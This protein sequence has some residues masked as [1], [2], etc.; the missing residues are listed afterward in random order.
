M[1]FTK[2]RLFLLCIITLCQQPISFGA[3]YLREVFLSGSLILWFLNGTYPNLWRQNQWRLLLCLNWVTVSMS[4]KKACSFINSVMIYSRNFFYVLTPMN[5]IHNQNTRW[6]AKNHMY[7]PLY[8][9]S[10]GQ[11]CISDT[12]PNAWNSIPSKIKPYAPMDIINIWEHYLM[13][14]LSDILLCYYVTMWCPDA[15]FHFTSV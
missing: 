1:T 4:G 9:T 10:R 11:K 12:G 15:L 14:S 3:H 5:I 8:A 6:Y 7:V 13:C 2:Y